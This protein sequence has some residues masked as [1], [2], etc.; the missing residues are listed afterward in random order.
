ML[1]VNA[2]AELTATA[3]LLHEGV[4]RD[5]EFCRCH[6]T[7]SGPGLSLPLRPARVHGVGEVHRL[8]NH[9][10]RP[11]EERRRD[12]QA[13]R[14]GGLEVDDQTNVLYTLDRKLIGTCPPKQLRNQ[15][16]GLTSF[17]LV[18]GSVGHESVQ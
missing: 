5:Q 15:S 18:V 9:L 16:R 7:T 12:R 6:L 13:Q 1:V 2:A 4:E 3:V 10:I 8:L 14:L 17:A 11:L